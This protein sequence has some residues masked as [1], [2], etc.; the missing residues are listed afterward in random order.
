MQRTNLINRLLILVLITFN[1]MLLHSQSLTQNIKGYI[2][3]KY[4]NLPL[5]GATI[6]IIQDGQVK[7][8]TANNKGYFIISGVKVG[9][10]DVA[11]SMIGYK[12]YVVKKLELVSGKEAYLEVE[13]EEQVEFMSGIVLEQVNKE[14]LSDRK[15]ME[16]VSFVSNKSFFFEETNLFAGSN[17]DPARMATNFAGVAS[18]G[19]RRN[20]IIVR[21]N[22]PGSI[23][24]RV[25][26]INVTNPNHFGS[27]GSSGGTVPILNNN[28]LKNANFLTGA[29]PYSYGNSISGAF[30]LKMRNGNSSK[31]EFLGQIGFNG[32]ELGVEGPFNSTSKASYLIYGRYSTLEVFDAMGLDFGFA[33]VPVFKDVTF[34]ANV[35]L[36][37]KYGKLTFFGIFG[38]SKINIDNTT[39][40]ESTFSASEA[41]RNVNFYS[42]TYIVG[43]QH[44]FYF[45]EKL[46]Q[47]L[48]FSFNML[49]NKTN[50]DS[51]SKNGGDKLKIVKPDFYV[52]ESYE[53]NNYI[54]YDLDYKLNKKNKFSI[55]S[56]VKLIS[57]KYTD[58]VQLERG[59]DQY[60]VL[61][62]YDSGTSLIEGYANY[63]YKLNMLE[64]N[65]GLHGQYFTFNKTSAIE[66]RASLKLNLNNKSNLSLSFGMHSQTLP[67]VLYL[68]KDNDGNENNRDLDLMKS[69]H[70]VAG[71]NYNIAPNWD[72][73]LEAYYQDISNAAV[74]KDKSNSYSSINAGDD[75]NIQGPDSLENKGTGSNLGL[76]LTLEKTLSD[77]YYFLLTTSIFQS[78][79]KGSDGKERNTA[80][81]NNFLVNLVGGVEFN[82]DPNNM[83]ILNFSS[84][85]NYTGGKPKRFIDE[86]ESKLTGN[87]QYDTDRDYTEKYPAYFRFDIRLGYKLNFKSFS[88]EWAVDIQNVFAVENVFRE[89][90]DNIEN[91]INTEYQLGLFPV[92]TYRILF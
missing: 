85:L 62:D 15:Q 76:E 69:I 16:K 11:F 66:P 89:A 81:N 80:W 73:Q 86:A 88:Q 29:F 19:D 12:P 38:D 3:D 83:H 77:N 53:I 58:S 31:T 71:Y 40:E 70:Y 35:P 46:K 60:R 90:W 78:K 52:N 21:G 64:F 1:F 6:S 8:T 17:G 14:S 4:S 13:L 59:S 72:I 10:T 65:A 68:Q 28:L 67:M 82:L 22:S 41:G 23:L 30:D 20:D 36:G 63:N 7:G 56:I 48:S 37:R 25:D 54:K 9:R 61:T 47:N 75:F 2:L 45:N 74:E 44:K 26:D 92:I 50:I 57:N 79:Y 24:W 42:E 18:S 43:A 27:L 49:G 34:K 5:E 39:N 33:A 55:G 91:K 32:V 84:K 87:T 51:L